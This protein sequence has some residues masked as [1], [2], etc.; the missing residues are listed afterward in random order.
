[1]S[2]YQGDDNQLAL[3]TCITG[4]SDNWT[5]KEWKWLVKQFVTSKWHANKQQ[6]TS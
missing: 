3:S 5:W 1:M 2:K 6:S 4:G